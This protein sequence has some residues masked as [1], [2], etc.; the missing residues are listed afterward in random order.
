[1]LKAL[2]PLGQVAHFAELGEF[3][4]FVELIGRTDATA[5]HLSGHG[6]PGTLVFEDELGLSRKV[7]SRPVRPPRPAAA[8]RARGHRAA[9][10]A[11]GWPR[12]TPPASAARAAPVRRPAPPSRTRGLGRHTTRQPSAARPRRRST[13]A[14]GD[15]FGRAM[16]H[17][18]SGCYPARPRTITRG[19]DFSQADPAEVPVTRNLD[20]HLP[21]ITRKRRSLASW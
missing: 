18:C 3:D 16:D 13:V 6:L 21:A 5:V 2:A 12:A 17:G 7:R 9:P 19:N 11:G 20:H 10:Q 14:A 1:M 15:G 4:D 8:A